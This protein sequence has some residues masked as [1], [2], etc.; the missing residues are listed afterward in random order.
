MR[1][2]LQLIEPEELTFDSSVQLLDI[3]EAAAFLRISVPTTRRLQRQ[4]EISFIKV[5][6]RVRFAK[7]D[8]LAY[9]RRKRVPA[10]HALI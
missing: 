10:M 7:S 6:G 4:R 5:G 9:L 1:K 2:K 3:K 8:L